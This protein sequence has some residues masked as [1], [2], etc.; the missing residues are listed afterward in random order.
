MARQV[1]SLAERKAEAREGDRAALDR[2]FD[3]VHRRGADERGDEQIHGSSEQA[4]RRV[5]LLEETVAQH[6]HTIPEGHR[7]HLVVRDVHGGG[8]KSLVQTSELGP[9]LNPKLGVQVGERLVHQE[10]DGFAD[11]R[12]P[13]RHALPLTARERRRL[14][15]EEVLDREHLRHLSSLPL[16][17]VLRHAAEF[18]A[19]R[20]VLLDRHVRIQGVVLEHHRDV[21]LLGRKVGDLLVVDPDLPGGD[22]LE[23]GEHAQDR[24]LP[25][26]GRSRPGP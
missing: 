9:H 10:G 8:P 18:Q 16:A 22:F 24:R 2:P 6:G 20:D 12:P 19:E 21:P 11:H 17:L 15:L 1:R 5:D 25:A 23:P 7:L 26:A 4:L 3:Q 13:H 14:P